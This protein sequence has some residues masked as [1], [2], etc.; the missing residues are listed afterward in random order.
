MM[1]ASVGRLFNKYY[2]F[3][4]RWTDCTVRLKD[5]IKEYLRPDCV[6]LNAGAA[7]AL[8]HDYKS[9][10]R[11]LIGVDIDKSVLANPTLDEAY[12]CDIARM[13]FED[14]KFDV[15]ILDYV[16]EHLED[17]TAAVLGIKRVLKP[18]GVI[19]LRTPNLYHYVYLI[20]SFIPRRFY[21]L[22]LN[23]VPIKTYYRCNSKRRIKRL[24]AG[25]GLELVRLE[26]VEPEPAYLVFSLP[27]FLLGVFY[28][29]LV[30]R[31][32]ALENFRGN[33]FAVFR[34]PK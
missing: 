11:T 30:N 6:A 34:K 28:E 14:A 22:F 17:P 20:G 10:V 9:S 16:L 7:D 18:G 27:A 12:V 2:T 32:Q 3:N 19:I 23:R 1:S 5:I 8:K 26:M 24:F 4:P 33:I 25:A 15:V 21:P 31:F 29:R 13:P